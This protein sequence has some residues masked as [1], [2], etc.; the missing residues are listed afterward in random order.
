[1]PRPK[2]YGSEAEKQRAYRLRKRGLVLVK[3]EV[4]VDDESPE[5][6]IAFCPKCKVERTDY[7]GEPD[8]YL[9]ECPNCGSDLSPQI[10]LPVSVLAK[11]N[12]ATEANSLTGGEARGSTNIVSAEL[13]DSRGGQTLSKTDQLMI[14]DHL[15]GDFVLGKSHDRQCL[16][17]NKEYSTRLEL[18]KF[19]SPK[20]RSKYI[21]NLVTM[22]RKGGD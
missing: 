6:G 16:N 3:K 5:T 4:I 15:G 22:S 11:P 12:R 18:N 7:E 17:C 19:C 8:K 10:N 9:P 2:R 20:C 13:Q 1:M 21:R 14:E